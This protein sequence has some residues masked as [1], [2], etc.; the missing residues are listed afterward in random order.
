[1]PPRGRLTTLTTLLVLMAL[2]GSCSREAVDVPSRPATPA[3]RSEANLPR[4]NP[5]DSFITYEF[6]IYYVPKAEVEPMP[7]AEGLLKETDFTRVDAISKKETSPVVELTL[8]DDRTGRYPAPSE[9]LLQQFGRGLSGEQVKSLQSPGQVLSLRFAY[10]GDR[11][12]ERLSIAM[13]LTH[14]IATAAKG[15]IWDNETREM[16]A[17]DRW[18]RRLEGWDTDG[19]DVSR[20]IS[21]HAYPSGDFVRAVT[22]GMAK[23]G[24][25][26]LVVE[27]FG[28]SLQRN[29]GISINL[30][31][32]AF[33]EGAKIDRPGEFDLNFRLIRHPRLRDAQLDNLEEHAT[34]IAAL[35]LKAGRHDEG[36]PD[37]RLW[38]LTFERGEGPDEQ[39]RMEH[40][41]SRAFGWKESVVHVTHDDEMREASRRA[42]TRLPKL[43]QAF[44]AGLAP[45]EVMLLKA[46][47]DTSDG[48]HEYMWVEVTRWTGDAVEGLLQNEPFNVPELKAGQKV[49]ISEATVFDYIWKHADGSSDGNET[50]RILEKQ[51]KNE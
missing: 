25:P 32:Q 43:K 7:L 21:I 19:P 18:N 24:L 45:G 49:Q 36:D 6:A 22:L 23:F 50:G 11:P 5:F 20:Q 10:P 15:V 38:Q 46:P 44:A 42:R 39:A 26:D 29:V 12:V 4:G 33:V 8:I 35:G 27:D 30:V 40:V 37:N 48:G 3:S 47:F 31:A 2:A 1:M 17:L 34:A 14:A 41:L 9:E 13:K 51:Q 28:W 16:F